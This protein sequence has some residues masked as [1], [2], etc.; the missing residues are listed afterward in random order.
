MY[1]KIPSQSTAN[2]GE[3]QDLPSKRNKKCFCLQTRDIGVTSA[4]IV[5]MFLVSFTAGLYEKFNSI[6]LPF[7]L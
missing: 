5:T 3:N 1:T 4:N 7:M 2:E 6:V